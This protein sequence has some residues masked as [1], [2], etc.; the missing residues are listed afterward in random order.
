MSARGSVECEVHCTLFSFTYFLIVEYIQPNHTRYVDTLYVHDFSV[1]LTLH[2][3][4]L[5]FVIPLIISSEE[6]NFVQHPIPLMRQYCIFVNILSHS[7]KSHDWPLINYFVSK[8]TLHKT[9]I[10]L[11]YNSCTPPKIT[12]SSSLNFNI[13][14]SHKTD[15][16]FA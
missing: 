1:L 5:Y 13:P 2:S 15:L 4:L 6:Q 9:E 8:H 14:L 10:I 3:Y 7:H 11:R 16:L 12:L